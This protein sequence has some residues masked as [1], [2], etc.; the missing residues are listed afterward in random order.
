MGTRAL[1]LFVYNSSTELMF[2]ASVC[3]KAD[4]SVPS[5]PWQPKRHNWH[6][7]AA[8]DF[9]CQ[10]QFSLPKIGAGLVF[11]GVILLICHPLLTRL[12]KTSVIKKPTT[13]KTHIKIP[14]QPDPDLFSLSLEQLHSHIVL[15]KYT[16]SVWIHCFVFHVC[17]SHVEKMPLLYKKPGAFHP[18]GSSRTVFTNKSNK[19]WGPG[20]PCGLGSLRFFC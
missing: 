17:L 3:T 1:G 13:Q 16:K 9:L 12:L 20:K 4:R 18:P 8:E 5:L 2:S 7:T 11:W 6:G 15:G 14:K 19:N 10:A